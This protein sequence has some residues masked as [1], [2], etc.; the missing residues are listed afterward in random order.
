MKKYGDK[1]CVITVG[2][3][4]SLLVLAT[5]LLPSQDFSDSERRK[6]AQL[7][8]LSLK[9]VTDGSFMKDFESYTQDQF[10][11]RDG[12][13]TL[14]AVTSYS[15]L[16]QLDN[17]QIYV[18]DGYA[19]KLEYPLNEDLLNHALDRF[20]A[21][22]AQYLKDT[23]VKIYSAVV[24]DKSYY[25]AGENGYLSMDYERLFDIVQER[26]NYSDYIDLTGTLTIADYYCTD[27]HWR[28]E[29][30]GDTA[31]ALAGAMGVSLSRD[32][33]VKALET[34]F[35]GVYY[36]QSALPLQAETIYYLT[37]DTLDGCVVTN[38][39]N[40][41]VGGIYDMEKAAGKD[42]YE[43]FLS[44]SVSL[45]T[46]ENPKAE[47][48]RELVIFRDSFGSSIAPLLAEGYSKITLVD[49]R[50]LRVDFLGQFLSFENQDV[51]FLYSTSVLNH[52]ETFT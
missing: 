12:F 44:G 6:L 46:L 38:F 34:P 19:A 45:L 49:I 21:I 47:G 37:N 27:T 4:F 25:L 41:A 30:L 48:N 39:E 33:K 42:P 2:L 28:Q 50:Y 7:P 35:Y 8:E 16:H 23:D 43:M 31:Q 22:Y 51:L 14:K 3:L 5:W 9:S 36:G 52:S 18:Q 1:I 26:M 40:G 20:D 29:Q 10:P 24:P 13:R 11:L 32:Y 15:V 17:N